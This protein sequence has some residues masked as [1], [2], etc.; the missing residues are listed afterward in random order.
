LIYNPSYE[1]PLD[2][3]SSE[4]AVGALGAN[5]G[6]G[7]AARPL[8]DGALRSEISPETTHGATQQINRTVVTTPM[9]DGSIF[10][11]MQRSNDDGKTWRGS[12]V[13][14]YRRVK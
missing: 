7:T 10:E 14:T 8:G 11:N 13:A 5:L 3:A 12:F 2:L 9:P 1:F 6:M 4:C